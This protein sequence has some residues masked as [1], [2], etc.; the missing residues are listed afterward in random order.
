MKTDEEIAAE[1]VAEEAAAAE[2]KKIEDA[3]IAA[4]A[5]KVPEGVSPEV[6][7]AAVAAQVEL[8]LKDLK[9]KLDGAFTERDKALAES[10]R[11]KE[12]QDAAKLA[13]LREDGKDKE[14]NDLI[15]AKAAAENTALREANVK[16]TRDI[17]VRNAVSAYSFK[18]E[19]AAKLATQQIV[20]ELVQNEQGVWVHKSG[21]SIPEYVKL[22]KSNS[23]NEF[24]FKPKIN[25]GSGE[26]Q[27]NA[28]GTPTIKKTTSIFD[29]PVADVLKD[30]AEGNLP[31]QKR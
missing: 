5:I 20:E 1:K 14:A 21:V 23:E 16:L 12:D 27:T 9:L 30:A 26:T 31:H 22:F 11:F 3:K 13:K 10:A 4:A 19:T 8:A 15:A 24:L 29:R 25:S 7:A 17:E 6:M 18:N 2:A 28:D